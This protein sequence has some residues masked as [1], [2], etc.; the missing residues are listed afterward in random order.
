MGKIKK[1]FSRWRWR[2]SLIALIVAFGFFGWR[3]VFGK[4]NNQPQFQTAKVVRGTLIASV[5]AS[6]KVLISDTVDVTTSATGV[7]KKVYVQD[8]DKVTKGQ[9]IA[10]ISLDQEGQ[11]SNAQ[12]WSS[13]LS[14]KNNL[15]SAQT[16]LHSLNSAMWAAQQKFL[17]DAVAKGLETDNPTYI[18]QNADW[19]AAESKYKNQQAIIEQAQASLNSAWLSYQS[20]SPI[21]TAPAS[22][23]IT[24][25]GLIEGMVLNS[26]GNSSAGQTTSQRVA[27]IQNES[28]PIISLSLTEIDLP[29][30]QIGQKATV[31]LDSLPDKTFTGKVATVDRIGTISNNVTSYQV[32]IQLDTKSPEILPN[33]AANANIITNT[34]LNVL[35]VP[36]AAVSTQGGIQFV[37]VLK[38]GKQEQVPVEIGLVG[39][40]QTEVIS[41]L[42]EGDEII[43]GAP[44]ATSTSRQGGSIFSGFGGNMRT[45]VPAMMQIRR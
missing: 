20:T 35:L 25:L 7:V 27:M 2:I 29:K 43:T 22:G 38:N 3:V 37:K 31:S 40:T 36:S 15:E 24:N 14:A 6:G 12:A 8:G 34:K 10:E 5:S 39:D 9:K 30:V 44:A 16:S 13:Y 45:R 1:L 32:L 41:G 26:S 42:S 33:M 18:Q 28:N 17:N 23:V 19:L 21:I 11:K 4:N